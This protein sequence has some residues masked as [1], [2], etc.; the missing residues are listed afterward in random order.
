MEKKKNSKLH[1]NLG[2]QNPFVL[3]I[4]VEGHLNFDVWK[5][6]NSTIIGI[7]TNGR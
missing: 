2:K 1:I 7:L 5:L 6:V 4:H 3:I